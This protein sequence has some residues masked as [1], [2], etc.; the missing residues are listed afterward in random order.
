MQ[1]DISGEGGSDPLTLPLCAPL[2]ETLSFFFVFF[3]PA[4][5]ADDGSKRTSRT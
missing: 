5:M 2:R 3:S 1:K 4:H